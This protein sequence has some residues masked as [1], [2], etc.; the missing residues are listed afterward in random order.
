MTRQARA[1]VFVGA[2]AAAALA[3]AVL[4][5]VPDA[6]AA[7]ASDSVVRTS[8]QGST[9]SGECLPRIERPSGYLDA[10]WQAYRERT[11]GDPQKDYYR[12]HV[13]A[14]FGPGPS[15]SPRWARLAADLVG[16]PADNVLMTWPSGEWDGPCDQQPVTIGLGGPPIVETICGHTAAAEPEPWTHV[17]TWT[18]RGCLIPDDHDRA[19]NLHVIVGVPEGEVPE[20][21]IAVD[22]GG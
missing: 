14:T 5:W 18:C 8:M 17:V 7:A 12:L 16:T 13:Y 21:D 22:V 4:R 1:I 15:G 9:N 10:C 3:F 19:L 11:D 2:A 6:P 20:W